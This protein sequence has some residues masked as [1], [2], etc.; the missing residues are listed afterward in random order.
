M[1]RVAL[2][3]GAARGM[4]AATALRLAEEGYDVLALDA[5]AG[6]TAHPYPMPTVDDLESV[7]ADPRAGGRVV[8]RVA[9]VRDPAAV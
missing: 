2:V 9:D 6:P 4:G 1:S 5:C 3:T 8:T 7:A